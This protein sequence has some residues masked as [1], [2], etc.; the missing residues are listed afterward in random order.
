MAISKKKKM[1]MIDT[2]VA[3]LKNA[4]AVLITEYRGLTVADISRLRRQVEE[5][6][7]SYLVVK[8][9]LFKRALQQVGMPVPEDLLKGPVAVGIVAKDAAGVS[10]TMSNF[11]VTND[12]LVIKGGLLGNTTMSKEQ[13]LALATL[14]SRDVLLSQVLAGL[15]SPIVGLVNVLS[16]PIR[17]LVY[18]MQARVDQL[19]PA[20]AEPEPEPVAA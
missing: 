11:K 13:A 17:G 18:V 12:L 19:T 14:P 1:T 2:Y 20:V 8:N 5:S 9:T 6:G 10:K 4:K 16:G 15:Q 7:A 3:A